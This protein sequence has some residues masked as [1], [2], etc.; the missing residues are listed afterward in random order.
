MKY[1]LTV[2]RGEYPQRILE[3]DNEDEA[4]SYFEDY[5]VMTAK[6]PEHVTLS[7]IDALGNVAVFRTNRNS[8][9]NHKPVMSDEDAEHC[10]TGGPLPDEDGMGGDCYNCKH[11]CKGCPGS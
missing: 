2:S 7:S 1:I 3:F 8:S 5:E 10:M 11:K 6:E 4:L 9:S